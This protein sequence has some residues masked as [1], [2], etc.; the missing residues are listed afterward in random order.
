MFLIMSLCDLLTKYLTP[1]GLIPKG[2]HHIVLSWLLAMRLALGK[3]GVD[4]VSNHE[5]I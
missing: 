4:E 5:K 3:P 1:K 2:F